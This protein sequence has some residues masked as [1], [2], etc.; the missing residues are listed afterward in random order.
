MLSLDLVW[1]GSGPGLDLVAGNREHFK[2]RPGALCSVGKIN[3]FM[4]F[5][6]NELGLDRIFKILIPEGLDLSIS[7]INDL[8]VKCEDPAVGRV[9]LVMLT[10]LIILVEGN[11]YANSWK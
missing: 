6:N 10:D 1:I 11:Y 7:G 8:P 9:C 5:I 3:L 4:I 2:R